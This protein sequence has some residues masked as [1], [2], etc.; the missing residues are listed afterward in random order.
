MEVLEAYA[1]NHRLQ[2]HKKPPVS[3]AGQLY[4]AIATEQR[5]LGISPPQSLYRAFSDFVR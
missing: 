4:V 3:N 5:V 2:Y 1:R